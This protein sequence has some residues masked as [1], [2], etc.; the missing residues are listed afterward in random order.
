[1]NLIAPLCLWLLAITDAGFAGF[2]DTAGRDAHIFKAELH[3]RGIR[4]G[5]RHGLALSTVAAL[6]VLTV[7]ALAP[8]PKARFAELL[9]LAQLLLLPLAVYAGMV[10]AAL[11]VWATAEA[12]LRT[13]A[14]IIV[15]GP[16]TLIR[17]WVIAAA[18]AFAAWRSPSLAAALAVAGACGLQL[19]VGPWLS[20]GWRSGPPPSLQ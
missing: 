16:F 20:R 13:L 3:R 5:M 9:V 2:R 11:G 8:A 7:I 19:L 14:S 18:G 12:D 17:P 1:V 15:L 4:R 10:L 6:M